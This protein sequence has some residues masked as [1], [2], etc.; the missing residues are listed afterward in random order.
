[1]A[2]D[3]TTAQPLSPSSSDSLKGGFDL[4]SAR[5]LEEKRRPTEIRSRTTP[6][7]KATTD[8]RRADF[9][10]AVTRMADQI[11]TS[12]TGLTPE[13]GE[14]GKEKFDRTLGTAISVGLMGPILTAGF[15]ALNQGK[16]FL[17]SGLKGEEYDALDRRMLSDLIPED[18]NKVVRVGANVG[19]TLLDIG[20]IGGASAL[21][22][23][24]ALK[25]TLKT[26]R[27][28]LAKSGRTLP[29]VSR[30]QLR[31]AA[32][33]TS[34]EE[35]A[36]NW[37]KAKRLRVPPLEAKKPRLSMQVD[38][39]MV[40]AEKPRLSM[41]VDPKTGEVSY[42]PKVKV[43]LVK[44]DRSPKVESSVVDPRSPAPLPAPKS[45]KDGGK[46]KVAWS[47]NDF[48]PTSTLNP[49]DPGTQR[50]VSEVNDRIRGK[51]EHALKVYEKGG[52]N[53]YT[54]NPLL[55]TP[56]A[57]Q[58]LEEMTGYPAYTRD[59]A[60]VNSGANNAAYEVASR[61]G[62]LTA[63]L[64]EGYLN[65]KSNERIVTWITK[66]KGKLNHEEQ[67]TANN[68]VDGLKRVKDM[69]SYLRMR[70]FIDGA[71]KVPSNLESMVLEGEK[72]F[73]EKGAKALEKW[74]KG[75]DFGVVT[76][77]RY[78]PAQLLYKFRTHVSSDPFD[79][80]NPHLH[81]RDLEV[82]RYD[83]S[84]SL[85]QKMHAYYSRIYS[86]YYLYDH[87]NAIKKDLSSTDVPFKTLDGYKR[88][89]ALSQGKGVSVG[90]IGDAMRKVRGQFFKT[91]LLDP[92]KWA[93]NYLQ[94][95][96]MTAQRYPLLSH[97]E[98]IA[99]H[100]AYKM[101]DAETDYFR[102][103]V[104]Q[105]GELERE[106]LYL[107][108]QI[109]DKG[110]A[111][112][113]D[114]AAIAGAHRYTLVDEGNRYATFK[115]FLASA[116]T[117]L[118]LYKEGRLSL[119][120]LMTK[121]G[122]S[123]FYDL[124]LK[125]VLSLPIEQARLEMARI[126]VEKTQARYKKRERG[127]A[128][129]SELGEVA[130]SLIQYP[131]TIIAAYL[132]AGKMITEGR[133]HEEMWNGVRQLV[134]LSVMAWLA[135][136]TLK[137][138][139][140]EHYYYDPD[141]GREVESDPYSLFSI[142]EGMGVGGAQIAHVQTVSRIGKRMFDLLSKDGREMSDKQRMTQIRG[143]LRDI[144]TLGE[145]YIPFLKIALNGMESLNDKRSYR[146]LTTWF[147]E[148][149][150]RQSAL[151]RNK[152]ERTWTEALQHAIFGR[153][154]SREDDRWRRRRRAIHSYIERSPQQSIDYSTIRRA[155]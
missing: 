17:V 23:E 70:R 62:E 30:E 74:V 106:Q 66:R 82:Q 31:Q 103:H 135:Q 137:S 37:W 45:V 78:F 100:R 16:N 149:T 109:F 55:D 58:R 127:V 134:G 155:K 61:M 114:K 88:W 83:Y 154:P 13:E 108:D 105:L 98:R 68:I 79:V 128:A 6:M 15:E 107:Y 96:Y 126:V 120:Q 59:Y 125:H 67:R 153:N 91:I 36:M 14:R 148:K 146:L 94:R 85:I 8:E 129:M 38:P 27:E 113:L 34:L 87:L 5:P 42:K 56:V 40:I 152:I 48:P 130:T 131:K 124:E 22:K 44:V 80:F 142:L 4:K 72:V 144:D 140:G 1:M 101:T 136:Q 52:P 118:R 60:A 122:I 46:A 99:R 2:F 119:P 65:A 9:D 43:D 110:W 18:V 32:R 112:K 133:T 76:D 7:P 92:S 104:S 102:R 49:S 111:G 123:D 77:D 73:S 11:F 84:Q 47:V 54:L 24:G 116:D 145:A 141:L 10:Y 29:G 50:V 150:N 81:S 51:M 75:K 35:A 93:R 143:I 71:E 25:S 89:L 21:A 64:K 39:K 151:R 57:L 86:D 69:V 132:D 63:G 3:L 95:Y 121:M 33:G 53:P 90:P 97:P 115:Y 20:L 138:V 147:D 41:R 12:S 26:I 19:E 139:I 28:K 117:P